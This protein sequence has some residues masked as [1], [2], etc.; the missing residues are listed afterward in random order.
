[1]PHPATPRR[2]EGRALAGTMQPPLQPIAPGTPRRACLAVRSQVVF[3]RSVATLEVSRPENLRA[4]EA[5]AGDGETFVAVPLADPQGDASPVRMHPVGTLVRL[6]DQI[7][8]PDGSRRIVVQGLHR[9]G[10]AGLT[11]EG[12]ILSAVAVE[13]GGA[14]GDEARLA[15]RVEHLLAL[16]RRLLENDPRYPEELGRVLALNRAE[17]G[18][19]ADLVASNLHLS[20]EDRARLLVEHEPG[21][22]LELLGEL[23][24]AELARAELTHELQHKVEERVRRGYLREQLAVIQGELGVADPLQDETRKLE[25]RITAAA[26]SPAA[27]AKALRELDRLRRSTPGS[28]EAS[29][30]RTWLEWVL[31]LPWGVTSPGPEELDA[32]FRDVIEAIDHTHTGLTDVKTRICEFLAVQHLGGE[33]RGTVLCFNGPSG[34]GKTSMAR[35]VATALGREFVQIPVGG[36]EDEDVLRGSH[37]LQP[38]AVA[39]LVLQGIQ[40][41]ATMNP[42]VLIDDLDGA[43]LAGGEAGGVLLQV[44]DRELNREFMDRYLGVPFDLSRCIFLA[45]ASDAEA[46]PD[47]LLDR[48]EFVSFGSYTEA[49]KLAI[50]REHLVPLA[51]ENAGLDRYQFKITPGAL[52]AIVREYTL[53]AGVR[54]LQRLLASLARKAAVEVLRGNYGLIVRKSRLPELLGPAI[55]D[56]DIHPA[57]PRIG[58]T[59]GLAWTTAG[60]ALLPIEALVMPGNGGLLLTGSVGDVMRESVQA[61]ISHVRTRFADLGI[62]LDALESVDLHL[63]FP[64]GA[65]PKDGPSAGIAIA[66]S[67]V[68]LLTRTAI[69]HDVAM[70]GELSL[71]GSVLPVGGLREKL[72][73]AVRAGIRTVVVPAR[74]REEV[75]RLPPEVRQRLDIRMVNDIAECLA[76]A[77]ITKPRSRV[78]EALA[79]HVRPR[80]RSPRRAAPGA[81]ANRRRRR[82]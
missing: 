69:R 53:E 63:H 45:T 75:L 70:T 36:V 12:G 13:L 73:A 61:S 81:A 54:Q 42:V 18:P 39:G 67:L 77:L 3:P 30:I 15:G 23:V 38:G 4:L 24:R 58:V 22:R 59:M 26:L 49:E 64:S 46:L 20:Y 6:L 29:R 33:A 56:E 71:H 52:R 11:D 2:D 40:R 74:N 51:R 35:A 57:R 9:V 60:G 79:E 19:F 82:S 5:H 48:L 47:A 43:R 68:S 76:E 31:D 16:I 34:T 66:T 80:K 27:R 65:T 28:T 62:A 25:Q 78:R 10:L 72:L 50:A 44:L 17:P 14:E 8:L 1:V 7:R 55:V 41:A 32:D 21:M 37:Y